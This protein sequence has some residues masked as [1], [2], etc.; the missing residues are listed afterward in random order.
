MVVNN[1]IDNPGSAAI[2]YGLQLG[3]WGMHPWVSRQIAIVGYVV[4]HGSATKAGLAAFLQG[5]AA[6]HARHGVRVL[7]ILAGPVDTA[8]TWPLRGLPFIASPGAFAAA[9]WHARN[10][11]GQV[12][13]PRI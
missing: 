10:R 5:Y 4:N 2:H 6:R 13:L 7:N 1:L 3:E 9:A 11:T 8:L 12:P